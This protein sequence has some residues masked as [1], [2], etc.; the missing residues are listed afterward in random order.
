MNRIF[1]SIWDFFHE[2][3]QVTGLQGKGE[4]ISLTP[5]YQFHPLHIHLDI[6]RA[7]TAENSPLHIASINT[8]HTTAVLLLATIIPEG[9]YAYENLIKHVRKN[10]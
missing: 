1:F 5:H 8:A 2:H 3:S 7:V 9:T 4:G 6:S 10:F